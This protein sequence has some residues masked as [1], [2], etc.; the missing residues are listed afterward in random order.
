MVATASA[1]STEVESTARLVRYA[2][3]MPP[4]PLG[5]PGGPDRAYIVYIAVA[6]AAVGFAAAGLRALYW[7]KKA[8][9]AYGR[10]SG[11]GRDGSMFSSGWRGGASDFGEFDRMNGGSYEGALF[12]TDNYSSESLSGSRSQHGG[13]SGILGGWRGGGRASGS[14]GPMEAET[15]QLKRPLL[16]PSSETSLMPQ[17]QQQTAAGSSTALRRSRDEPKESRGVGGG[18]GKLSSAINRASEGSPPPFSRIMGTM[19]GGPQTTS[20]G[21]RKKSARGGDVGGSGGQRFSERRARERRTK[22]VSFEESGEAAVEKGPFGDHD[23][24]DPFIGGGGGG[25]G[26]N[27]ALKRGDEA[28]GDEVFC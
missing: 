27:G 17:T 6:L 4:R 28:D 24:N 12:P 19:G 16:N 26:G 14:G 2:P 21:G 7:R 22:E 8:S 11:E 18:S 25:G 13:G 15:V 5:P 3:A 9:V 10:G 20:P 1:A 23:N